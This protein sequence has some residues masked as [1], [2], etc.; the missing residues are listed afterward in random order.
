MYVASMDSLDAALRR[1]EKHLATSK[2]QDNQADV[3]LEHS[4][5][6]NV[7]DIVVCVIICL[8]DI[9]PVTE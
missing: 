5:E 6:P 9:F 7:D 1:A 8:T 4:I 3:L 2:E